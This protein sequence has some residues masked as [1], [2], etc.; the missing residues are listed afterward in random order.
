MT[1]RFYSG[2]PEA[3]VS[4]TAEDGTPLPAGVT[5]DT[6]ERSPTLRGYIREE[7]AKI[8]DAIRQLER[9]MINLEKQVS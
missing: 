4:E 8:M 2:E 5:R 3:P 9:R 1:D 7:N 6:R